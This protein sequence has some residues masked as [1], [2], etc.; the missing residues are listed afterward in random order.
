MCRINEKY[1]YGADGRRRTFGDTTTLCDKSRHGKV[2]SN[3]ERRSIQYQAPPIPHD[4][5]PSPSFYSPPTPTGSG[6]YLVRTAEPPAP[7]RGSFARDGTRVIKPEIV[8]EIGKNSKGKRYT[9]LSIKAKRTSLG[10]MSTGS[11]DALESP[12]SEASFTANT[13]LL[14]HPVPL[15]P[16]PGF[17]ARPVAPQGHRHT[18]STSSITT[19][20]RP[21]SLIVTSG[22]ESPSARRALRYPITIHN[23]PLETIPQA[24]LGSPSTLAPGSTSHY[25][26]RI[27][28]PQNSRES[29]PDAPT[30]PIDYSLYQNMATSAKASA[31]TAAAIEIIQR[32]EARARMRHETMD[33]AK[34]READN[35]RQE[36]ADYEMAK[37]IAQEE[38]ARQAQLERGRAE[39]R[40]KERAENQLAHSEKRRAEEREEVRKLKQQDKGRAER[41]AQ[42]AR[43]QAELLQEVVSRK[44]PGTKDT[45]HKHRRKDR[46]SRPPTRDFTRQSRRRSVSRHDIIE[47]NRMLATDEGQ[48]A[49]EREAA[50]R[51][52]REEKAASLIQQ[53]QQTQYY[54]PRGGNRV[55]LPNDPGMIR[56]NSVSA[57][58]GSI[59]SAVLPPL[60]TD[61]QRRVSI[62]QPQPPVLSPTTAYG[63]PIFSPVAPASN[64]F[65]RPPSARHSSYDTESTLA[66]HPRRSNTS[67]I[68]DNPFATEEGPIDP[69]DSRD[70]RDALTRPGL[71]TRQ[72]SDDRHHR[73]L[74]RRDE[75]IESARQGHADRARQATRAIRKVVDFV[76]D[77]ESEEEEEEFE[78]RRRG[79]GKGRKTR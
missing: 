38:E 11:N 63:T 62:I 34:K 58:R 20:S 12:G 35:R 75:G 24:P 78:E 28:S 22:A 23:S 53:Q 31:D 67:Q 61:R 17:T 64:A 40:A 52:E 70:L 68:G 45:E 25:R 48:M 49:L 32:D 76:S 72:P 77:E 15:G 41:A 42:E 29:V 13:G 4:E 69:W 59:S 47:R 39:Q 33:A 36:R 16:T 37:N 18:S 51:R 5:T 56:R 65:A 66:Q 60:T 30:S 27:V 21:P 19:S 44:E 9:G 1:F 2:C 26:T 74:R 79:K 14:E 46:D 8:I 54:D 55:P 3:V 7:R 50:E 73:S 43:R 71:H 6:T 10:A 57:R